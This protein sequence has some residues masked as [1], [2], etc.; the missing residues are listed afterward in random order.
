VVAIGC[1]QFGDH[2]SARRGDTRRGRI[3]VASEL[4]R[5]AIHQQS[6]DIFATLTFATLTCVGAVASKE[7]DDGAAESAWL[8]QQVLPEIMG[9]FGVFTRLREK[10][11][12]D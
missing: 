10:I 6:A 11:F 3:E 4:Y 2:R 5:A 12:C 8:P 1:L 7:K 9:E